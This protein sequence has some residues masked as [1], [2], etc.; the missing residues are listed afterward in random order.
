MPHYFTLL[1]TMT[2]IV[3]RSAARPRAKHIH[4]CERVQYAYTHTLWGNSS[5]QILMRISGFI[6][7]LIFLVFVSMAFR[8]I[9]V[10][11]C[12][13]ALVLL[14][15]PPSALSFIKSWQKL[16]VYYHLTFKFQRYRCEQKKIKNC[17]FITKFSTFDSLVEKRKKNPTHF[18]IRLTL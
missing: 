1:P 7:A 12:K 10:L 8:M 9:C 5:T 18:L 17:K 3:L 15:P 13:L 11:W 6:G 14:L 4:V 2:K 16:C